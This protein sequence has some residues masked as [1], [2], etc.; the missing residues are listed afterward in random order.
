MAN[1]RLLLAGLRDAGAYLDSQGVERPARLEWA[2]KARRDPNEPGK[3][4]KEAQQDKLALQFRRLFARQK[5]DVEARLGVL[6]PLKAYQLPFDA[7]IFAD[8]E[9]E[10]EIMK[11]LLYS[12]LNGVEMFQAAMTLQ[13]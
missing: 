7:T 10:A 13:M 6:F 11:I 3:K 4:E 8:P 5:K 12:T 9:A 1:S 2:L